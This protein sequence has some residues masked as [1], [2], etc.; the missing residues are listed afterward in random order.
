MNI[1]I[2]IYFTYFDINIKIKMLSNI[3]IKIFDIIFD[4]TK[5]SNIKEIIF[6]YFSNEC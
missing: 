3:N 4:K 5:I 2:F 1:D 6:L